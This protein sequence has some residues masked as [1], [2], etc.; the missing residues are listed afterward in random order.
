MN[1]AIAAD[2]G[3]YELKEALKT[4][5]QNL[6]MADLG[7]Y[8]AESVDYPD[9]A[10]KMAHAVLSKMADLGILICGTGIGISIAANRFKGIRAALIYSQDA[11]RLAKEHNNANVL[12]FGGRTMAVDDVIKYIDTFMQSTYQGGRH[13]R[14][15]DK[16]DNME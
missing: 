1:I 8:D 14:R 7:T 16:L 15:L 4:H 9:M 10:Q 11:A 6:K 5:Y 3:G 12:V 13:Q 2:H